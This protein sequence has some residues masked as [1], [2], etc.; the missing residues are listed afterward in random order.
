M[1][2]R[3]SEVKPLSPTPRADAQGSGWRD[4]TEDALEGICNSKRS[5]GSTPPVDQ[6]LRAQPLRSCD[7]EEET[8][9]SHD[10]PAME[11]R[12]SHRHAACR[13]MALDLSQYRMVTTP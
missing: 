4:G 6:P 3:P 11:W 7:P 13:S 10:L 5:E 1:A 2:V 12:P 9:I 8:A